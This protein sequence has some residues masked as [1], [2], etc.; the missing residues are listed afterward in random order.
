M[1]V[2]TL[3]AARPMPTVSQVSAERDQDQ[4][5]DHTNHSSGPV[6]ERKHPS[7]NVKAVTMIKANPVLMTAPSA[8]PVG[9]DTRAMALVR[10]RAMIPMVMWCAVEIAVPSATLATS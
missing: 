4:Q 7:R 6:S 1:A 9:T 8:W 5:P 3:S 10:S 2:S